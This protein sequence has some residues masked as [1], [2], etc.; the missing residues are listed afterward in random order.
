M[1]NKVGTGGLGTGIVDN[2]PYS[3]KKY[4]FKFKRRKRRRQ[5]ARLLVRLEVYGSMRV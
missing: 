2:M 4:T 5:I 1:G 3:V